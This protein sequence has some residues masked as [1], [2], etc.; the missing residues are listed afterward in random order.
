MINADKFIEKLVEHAINISIIE[1]KGY[2]YI[3]LDGFGVD[4]ATKYLKKRGF[5]LLNDGGNT[6]KIVP[7]EIKETT[8]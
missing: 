2:A 8:K 1:K 3:M 6:Y 4:K 7:G 5:S